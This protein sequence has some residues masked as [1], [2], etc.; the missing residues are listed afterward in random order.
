MRKTILED[1]LKELLEQ[2]IDKLDKGEIKNL[3]LSNYKYFKYLDLEYLIKVIPRYE[4]FYYE[5]KVHLVGNW[6]RLLKGT[7]INDLMAELYN[8][9]LDFEKD[10][11]KVLSRFIFLISQ[12]RENS[13]Y[14]IESYF[15]TLENKEIFISKM[16]YSII[17]EDIE[18]IKM[19]LLYSY[20]GVPRYMEI[21]NCYNLMEAITN[22]L[23]GVDNE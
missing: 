15:K 19:T 23:K 7:T 8:L 1:E 20:K 3:D 21:D 12:K 5:L 14:Y 6:Y 22:E 16:F 17:D 13:I 9:Y 18:T 10:N 2:G 11:Q 4:D